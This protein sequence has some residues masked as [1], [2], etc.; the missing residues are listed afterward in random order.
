MV[1]FATPAR[2]ATSSRR[3]AVKPRA[4][5]SSSAAATMAARRSAA[6][7]A[8]LDAGAGSPVSD[9]PCLLLSIVDN[10]TDQSVIVKAFCSPKPLAR[11]QCRALNATGILERPWAAEFRC[12]ERARRHDPHQG[13]ARPWPELA[14]EF[15]PIDDLVDHFALATEGEPD[16]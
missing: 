14:V 12:R 10:M 3:V 2:L 4:T 15:Q 6:R 7:S 9:M 11:A 5:N 13:E 16:Q 1:P 8:R